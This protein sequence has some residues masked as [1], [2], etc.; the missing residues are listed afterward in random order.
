MTAFLGFCG[1]AARLR[2]ELPGAGWER[3]RFMIVGAVY[4][5]T[6]YCAK[7]N[8]APLRDNWQMS[9]LP[10]KAQECESG[11][12][13][14]DDEHED[15]THPLAGKRTRFHILKGGSVI[16]TVDI[17]KQTIETKDVRLSDFFSQLI[18]EGIT[19][20]P[21]NRCRFALDLAWAIPGVI[22]PTPSANR[23]KHKKRSR[24]SKRSSGKRSQERGVDGA[25][26]AIRVTNHPTTNP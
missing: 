26:E 6:G 12:I 24:R 20:R 8:R 22:T 1:V 11:S 17:K 16:A 3:S 13:T 14:L 5:P 25:T 15:W 7:A 18:D 4:T 9:L 19:S 2:G 21:A 23:G 10:G